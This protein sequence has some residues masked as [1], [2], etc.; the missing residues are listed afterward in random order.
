MTTQKR[1]VASK[2]PKPAG[3]NKRP[4]T[5]GKSRLADPEA[6]ILFVIWHSYRAVGIDEIADEHYRYFGPG[7]KKSEATIRGIISRIKK[8]ERDFGWRYLKSSSGKKHF[9]EIDTN[10]SV[11]SQGTATLL[12]ELKKGYFEFGKSLKEISKERF[13]QYLHERY[14]PSSSDLFQGP[15]DINDRIKLARA[16]GFLEFGKYRTIKAAS[17]LDFDLPYLL[18]IVEDYSKDSKSMTEELRS[19]LRSLISLFGHRSQRDVS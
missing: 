16:N 9:H 11:D 5:V 8:I 4:T 13:E 15:T 7:E 2:S 14:L 6:E 1:G 18:L 12:L 17:R 3:P 10:R 19:N